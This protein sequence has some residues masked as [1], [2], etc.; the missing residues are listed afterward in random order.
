MRKLGIRNYT[1]ISRGVKTHG[2]YNPDEILY[3]FEEELYAVQVKEIIA[4]L[5]W[6]HENNKTFGSGNYEQVFS[7]WRVFLKANFIPTPKGIKR[8][9]DDEGFQILPGLKLKK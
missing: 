7:E 9:F 6:V 5:K 3:L 4:F 8:R 1:L 2:T